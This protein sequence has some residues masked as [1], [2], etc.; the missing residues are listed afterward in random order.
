MI[1]WDSGSKC[2]AQVKASE[3]K[4]HPHKGTPPTSGQPAAPGKSAKDADVD[5]LARLRRRVFQP[6]QE[7]I[8]L[9]INRLIDRLGWIAATSLLVGIT[10]AGG[11]AVRMWNNP[12]EARRTMT[13]A[14]FYLEARNPAPPQDPRVS[15]VIRDLTNRL[16]DD[17]SPSN[18]R[19]DDTYGPWTQAQMAV[20]LQG[21][22]AFDAT[23]MAQ[24]FGRIA[25]NCNCWRDNLRGPHGHLA[26]TGWVL[27][28]F[29]RMRVRPTEPE[30]EF[31]LANQHR[32]GWWPIYATASDDPRNGSAYA[33]AFCAW[34]LQELLDRGLIADTQRQRAADAVRK[35][36]IWL[37]D[38]SVPGRPG[39]WK[40]YP[41]GGVEYGAE[42]LGLSG[43]VLH[44]L[45]RTPGPPPSANDADWML[46]LP[47]E[48]P[49]LRDKFSSGQTVRFP[50]QSWRPDATHHFAFPWL[51]VATTDAY[52]HGSLSQRAQAARLFH[53]I[54]E[55]RQ[56]LATEF[57]D[58]PF[59]AAETLIAL[60]HLRGDGV[61]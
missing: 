19:Y 3:Q 53:Q 28:S 57:K 2:R 54:P 41:N 9:P 43:L 5:P 22:D 46:T 16:K 26:A 4:E 20:S 40:D 13:V 50:D 47:A 1:A 45:H 6:I 60:R 21:Q 25:G 51:I 38:N 27:L 34:A 18:R 11:L 49:E 35:G 12:D 15:E 10:V 29:A 56:A 31:L 52:S 48:L 24:W 42:S 37:V 32:P 8:Y 59:F 58:M 61:I 7:K 44:V 17:I 33:T 36:R 55:K 39:R 14:R 23:E 30:I